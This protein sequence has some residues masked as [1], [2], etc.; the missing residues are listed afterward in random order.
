MAAGDLSNWAGNY[1]KI[2]GS[3]TDVR[4]KSAVI[5]R[6]LKLDG[7]AKKVGE[8][9]VENVALQLPNGFTFAGTSGAVATLNAASSGVYKQ[10]TVT[11]SEMILRDVISYGTLARAAAEGEGAFQSAT[12]L[13]AMGMQVAMVN[14]VEASLLHGQRGYGTVESRTTAT[15]SGTVTFSAA[16]WAPGLWWAFGVGSS[17]D[18]FTGTTKNNGVAPLVVTAINAATRTVSFTCDSGT[19]FSGECTAGDVFYPLGANAGSSSFKEMLGLLSQASNTGSMHG[20]DAATYSNWLGNTYDV[21]GPFGHAVLED[22]IAQLRDRGAGDLTLTALVGSKLYGQL[23]VELSQ[24]RNLDASYSSEKAKQGFKAI[25]YASPMVGD[26]EVVL[27]PFMK[28]GE[29]AVLPLEDEVVRVGSTDITLGI[30]GMDE[31]FFRLVP[32]STSVEVQNYTDQAVL[33]KKPGCS[34]VFTGI[35]Y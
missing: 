8:S 24:T 1:K 7:K 30:P 21:S 25:S 20:I 10:A 28:N 4:T 13:L 2:Y 32:D 27:H 34:M 16:T 17:W 3:T 14:R 12:S 23:V 33:L 6:R 31:S 15:G 11:P 35:T 19:A 5:Q 29:C 26:V 18:S 22:G 9:Y